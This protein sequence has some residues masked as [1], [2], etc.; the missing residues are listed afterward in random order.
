VTPAPRPRDSQRARLYRAEGLVDAGRRLPTVERMQAWVDA[1]AATEWFVARWGARSFEVR[2]GFG[3]RRATADQAN[4]VL[5]MPKWA[6]S[7]LVLLHEIAHC[8]T[9]AACASHGPEYAGVLLALARRGMGVSTAQL[10]EDAFAR[11]RVRWTLAAVPEGRGHPQSSVR[12]ERMA[13]SL[14]SVSSHSAS[15]SE[16]ATMP[17][18]ATSR[19][20]VPSRVALRRATAQS[21]SPRAS[22]QPTGPA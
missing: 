12:A 18:P 3:H 9:P 11:E 8:L 22:T 16:P 2:P 6:R 5:Q 4:G 10:L 17:A 1:L 21:P 7:E 20:R 14:A 15:G 19:A 13:A